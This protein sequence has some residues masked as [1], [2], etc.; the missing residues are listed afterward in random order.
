VVAG[1]VE[2]GFVVGGF[3]FVVGGFCPLLA[4]CKLLADT[5]LAGTLLDFC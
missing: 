2:A 3:G 5:R 4:A 1:F